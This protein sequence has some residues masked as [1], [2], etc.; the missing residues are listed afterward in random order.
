MSIELEI[1]K[2]TSIK[3][4]P[5]DADFRQWVSGALTGSSEAV[6]TVR[7]VDREESRILNAKFRQQDKATNV[8][9][10]PAEL[11]PHVEL[12]LLGDI[13]ICAPLVLEQALEQGKIARAH[14][15]HLS[16]HGVL[17]LLGYDHQDDESAVE[18]EALETK[19]MNQLG[20]PDPYL[21]EKR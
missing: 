1:Q 11:P 16:I 14:W 17:H 15:A 9:S 21:R 8:L 2:V 20:F 10:F 19:I 18:M 4:V 6:L 3:D 5:S 7:L 13:V 12:P